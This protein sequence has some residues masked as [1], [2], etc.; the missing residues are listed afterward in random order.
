MIAIPGESTR[1]G[2]V[3]ERIRQ[4]MERV[5]F[6]ETRVDPMG[7]L[8][9]RIGSGKKVI[10]MDAHTDTVGIGDPREWSW[11]P[12]Q[13]KVEDGY[14]YGRGACDQRAGMASMVYAGKL[15]KELASWPTTRCTWSDPYRKKT[16]TAWR[17]ST[18]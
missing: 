8:L 13:G 11:D 5:G 17:G 1:E 2:P 9:G 4:E 10:M 7:N 16:A 18:Y 6:D 14:V 12:Y 3:I 15:I